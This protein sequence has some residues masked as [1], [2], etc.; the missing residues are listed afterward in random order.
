MKTIFL[1]AALFSFQAFAAPD[2][3]CF[4]KTEEGSDVEIVMDLSDEASLVAKIN[5]QV[6]LEFSGNEVS[7][8]TADRA[9]FEQ[10]IIG[11]NEGEAE[12]IYMGVNPNTNKG[13]AL[14]NAG[15]INSFMNIECQ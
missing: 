15:S 3:T 7:I 8:E 5:Q 13:S 2:M 1:F 14:I 6:V 12:S 11:R 10:I 9:P 4:G